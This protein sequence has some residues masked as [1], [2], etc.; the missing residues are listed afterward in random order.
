MNPLPTEQVHSTL[1]V[2]L[3]VLSDEG[4]RI[5]GNMLEGVVSGKTL[6]RSIIGGQLVI[7]QPTPPEQKGPAEKPKAKPKAKKELDVK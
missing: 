4:V 3:A 5:P 7:C 2:L 6:I 1:Q